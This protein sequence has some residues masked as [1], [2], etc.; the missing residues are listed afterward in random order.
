[1]R[2]TNVLGNV[3]RVSNNFNA[4]FDADNQVALKSTLADLA[5]L[6]HAMAGQKG[7]VS[8]G[9]AASANRPPAARP[10][11]GWANRRRPPAPGERARP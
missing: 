6:A 11:C 4:V 10:A 9:L 5:I 7:S 1:M 3:D 8:A 2:R